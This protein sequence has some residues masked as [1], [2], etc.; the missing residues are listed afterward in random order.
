MKS[1]E[2]LEIIAKKVPF[3]IH[4]DHNEREFKTQ[5]YD[6]NFSTTKKLSEEEHYDYVLSKLL[7][8]GLESLKN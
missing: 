1:K 5:I 8:K 4:S 3:T 2:L 6:W 7:R